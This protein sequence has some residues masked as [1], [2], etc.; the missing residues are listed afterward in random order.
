VF[1]NLFSIT[2]P[3]IGKYFSGIHFPKGNYFPANKRGLC[4]NK[5]KVMLDEE[6]KNGQSC[7]RR[8]KIKKIKENKRKEKYSIV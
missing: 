2:L 4:E 1:C 3:N 7:Q 6:R 5:E 8:K